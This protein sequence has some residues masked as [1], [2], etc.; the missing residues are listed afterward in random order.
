MFPVLIGFLGGW[1]HPGGLASGK[2]GWQESSLT[3]HEGFVHSCS[4]T[5]RKRQH[6]V[7]QYVAALL[8]TK[9]SA[10]RVACVLVNV[11]LPHAHS[12]PLLPD[13]RK[14]HHVV[15]ATSSQGNVSRG[16]RG[17]LAGHW[18]YCCPR[19]NRQLLRLWGKTSLSSMVHRTER[20][21]AFQKRRWRCL[22][23]SR[24]SREIWSFPKCLPSQRNSQSR[25]RTTHWGMAGSEWSGCA[26][27]SP[28]QVPH[29]PHTWKVQKHSWRD[30]Q[31]KA[32]TCSFLFP[33][34]AVNP[35]TQSFWFNYMFIK[36]ITC[37]LVSLRG[38]EPSHWF[39]KPVWVLKD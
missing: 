26:R 33:L 24:C 31:D 30:A 18:N 14:C 9:A 13:S 22:L 12:S 36:W 29:T 21:G 34:F 39:D 37:L 19:Q 35:F 32:F 5:A 28:W 15:P 7:S 2:A 4:W 25:A 11:H 38:L 17:T 6:T 3:P 8:L 27:P 20:E 1:E 16:K 23:V 10:F